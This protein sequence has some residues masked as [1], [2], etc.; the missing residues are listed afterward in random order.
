MVTVENLTGDPGGDLVD[1]GDGNPLNPGTAG[2]D[3][4]SIE[5]G[6][7][8]DTI[9]GRA[10]TP[11]AVKTAMTSSMATAEMLVVIGRR[12]GYQPSTR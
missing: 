3:S 10:T 2:G 7:G 1:N 5:A 11:F 4:D 9:T 12:I 8:N 6:A